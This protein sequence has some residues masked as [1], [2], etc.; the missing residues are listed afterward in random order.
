VNLTL[1]FDYALHGLE[2]RGYHLTN[3]LLHLAVG[4]AL[5][6]VLRRTLEKISATRAV[7]DWAAWASTLLW[8]LHP[9]LTESVICIVQ[10]NELLAALFFLLTL[11]AFLRGRPVV[12][13]LTC[14]LGMASKEVMVVTPVL[15]LLY[16][17]TFT[18]GSFAEAWR[19]HRRRHLAL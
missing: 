7:A 9:L 8:L 14:A 4:F 10:R 15:V 18:S 3:L 2:P 16:D 19:R 1:A 6:T 13:V 5:W 12:A 17:R 11:L